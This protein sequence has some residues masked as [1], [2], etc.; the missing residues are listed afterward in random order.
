MLRVN[1]RDK[2]TNAEVLRRVGKRLHFKEEM[3]KRKLKYAGH[4]LRGSGGQ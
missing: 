3:K 4:V 1:W 2:I